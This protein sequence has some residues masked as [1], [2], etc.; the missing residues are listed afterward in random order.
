VTQVALIEEVVAGQGPALDLVHPFPRV[1]AQE[2]VLDLLPTM[3]LLLI[4]PK[5]LKVAASVIAPTLV[6]D[7]GIDVKENL[8]L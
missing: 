2:L 7:K 1:L 4:F 8:V 6:R 5:D 3:G